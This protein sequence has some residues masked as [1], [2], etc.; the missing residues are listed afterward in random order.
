MNHRIHVFSSRLTPR[1]SR[2]GFTLLELVV[3]VTLLALM[4]MLLARVFSEST[5]AVG[6]GS[7]QALLD[8]TARMLLDNIEQDVGQALVRTNVAFRVNTV[9]VGDALYCIST[10]IRR[11]QE[12]NPRDTAPIRIRSSQKTS[13]ANGLE[14]DLNHYVKF[15]YASGATGVNGITNLI[16]QSDYYRAAAVS[17]GGEADY[18]EPLASTDGAVDH[19]SL[20]FMDFLINGDS[21][22]NRSGNQLPGLADMPR[23]VDVALG[24]VSAK[25]MQQ[26]MRLH[27]AQGSSAAD[28]FIQTRERVY[29]RRIFLRNTSTDQLVF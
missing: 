8:E 12:T 22:S 7:E 29:T 11:R 5:Q 14:P 15:E 28:E 27:A 2:S 25:E 1:A 9:S 4:A 16:R 20:T 18:T 26:A 10:A 24:L 3:S 17:L 21:A 6:Q 23:F 13:T 19:A